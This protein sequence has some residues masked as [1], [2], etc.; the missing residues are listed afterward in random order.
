M[1]KKVIR[2]TESELKRMIK[3]II[4]EQPV[5][6]AAAAPAQG[7]KKD[8]LNSK[9]RNQNADLFADAAKTQQLGRYKI[10]SLGTS[11]DGKPNSMIMLTVANLQELTNT[12]GDAYGGYK[13]P[14]SIKSIQISCDHMSLYATKNN[15]KTMEVYCPGLLAVLKD[16]LNCKMIDRN[17][18]FSSTGGSAAGASFA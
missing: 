17:Q 12:G 18:G 8:V 11:A 9:V 3:N 6:G 15:G 7:I 4:S 13:D 14:E 5:P 1:S 16:A 10:V 2:L